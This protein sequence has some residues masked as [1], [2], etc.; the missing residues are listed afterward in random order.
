MGENEIPKVEWQ[1]IP[2]LPN[3]PLAS[4]TFLSKT[5]V[6]SHAHGSPFQKFN[7]ANSLLI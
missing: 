1:M 3:Q 4:K 2:Q 6:A 7:D 5:F